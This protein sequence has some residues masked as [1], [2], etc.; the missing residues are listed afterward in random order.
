MSEHGQRTWRTLWR[1]RARR[2][3]WA[4]L[5]CV[6]CALLFTWWL[7]RD[8]PLIAQLTNY[9]P[10]L[11]SMVLDRNG[12]VI[13]EFYEERRVLVELDAL[14]KYVLRAFIA[15]E[16]GAFYE[17]HGIDYRALM[18][19][20]RAVLAAGGEK[21]QGGST[22]TQQ[23]VKQLL[24]TPEKSYRRKLRE[25]ILA[26]EVEKRFSKDRILYLYLNHIYFGSGAYGIGEAARTYFDKNASALSVSEAALL[27][28]LPQRPSR[29]SPFRK[30]AAAEARRRYVLARMRDTGALSSEEYERAR[31][32]PP[33]LRE[34]AR[35][36]QAAA[37]YVTEEV[38]RRLTRALGNDVVLGGGLRIETSVDFALQQEAVTALRTGIEELDHRRGWRG[39][40]RRVTAGEIPALISELAAQNGLAESASVV[41]ATATENADATAV[42]DAAAAS[43]S[44][45][46]NLYT[47]EAVNTLELRA[48][49]PN[50]PRA[51]FDAPRL[52]VVRAVDAK[53][54]RAIVAFGAGAEAEATLADHRW[55]H[56]PE[57]ALHNTQVEDIAQIFTPGDVARFALTRASVKTV[58][59]QL[60]QT[61][62]AQGALLS[63]DL[64]NGDVLAMV[65]GYDFSQS[66]FN[67]ALQ[68][69]RQPGSAFKPIVFGAAVN[70]G[71]TPATL[72]YDRPVV[73]EDAATGFVF[74]PENYGRRF[75]G[76][77]TMTEALARSV[78][79]ATI[80]LLR[81]IGVG[82]V[83]EFAG[84]LGIRSPL[85]R[86][87][88]L[89]LGASPVTL[90][91]LTRAYG[92][93]GAGGR[94][95][96]PRLVLRVTD[97]HGKVLLENLPLDPE[98]FALP[99]SAGDGDGDNA[100]NADGDGNSVAGNN[101]T[102]ADGTTVT[103]TNADSNNA[104]TSTGVTDGD[105]NITGNNSATDDN[106]VT[107]DTN[108]EPTL[109]PGYIMHPAD[110][111][112]ATSL[113]RAT[114]EHP[115]GTGARARALRRPVA[116]KTGTTNDNTDA[117]FVGFT[118]AVATGVWVGI[119]ERQFLGPGET[120]GRVAAPIWVKYMRRALAER[121]T[122]E[123]ETPD[124]IVFARI[125]TRSGQLANARS[126]TPLFQAFRTG[127]EPRAGTTPRTNDPQKR[128][129]RLDF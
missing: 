45:A 24:L 106:A 101:N 117:W 18:R 2:A 91:E 89:A 32:A 69:Q 111:Y 120:G 48:T 73:H 116:A 78:N 25:L 107:T 66:E 10:P 76:P 72:L 8:F 82:R 26:R 50:L 83:I 36:A 34:D 88:G 49:P 55:A 3:A 56:A 4:L 97:R 125:D 85:E 47:A 46:E 68:A 11:T 98:L 52:G 90:L 70:S 123:F 113:L 63:F 54:Q 118:P 39:P 53:A 96:E 19:A 61:P 33:V 7:R 95:V 109:P 40:E 124:G 67:R 43:P 103:G 93:F 29:Y 9:Q 119:D 13:G 60:W 28:G 80:H 44:P 71:H 6:L 129:L 104:V 20:A 81:D 77:L 37:R 12:V 17:H 35:A 108:A 114:V 22:I 27:A 100:N 74:R 41:T 58:R 38:R 94:Y 92:V 121:E 105:N 99:T 14:P 57:R 127:T 102:N 115:R 112:I 65:G 42:T 64:Q 79:N 15:S 1:G 84:A 21:V 59:A 31:H 62:E 75:L 87:L 51:F 86:A 30:P 126:E 122:A 16:D 23:M 110:A 128:H 5:A